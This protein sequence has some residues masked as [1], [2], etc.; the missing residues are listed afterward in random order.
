MV[1][2]LATIMSTVDSYGFLAAVTFGRDI[3][4]RAR[5][6]RGDSNRYS[7]LGIWV[8]GLVSIALALWRESIVGLW[9]DLGSI[10]TPALLFPLALS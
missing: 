8:T 6:S 3:L 5:G 4:W 9:H 7:R 2:L 10:G 1:G